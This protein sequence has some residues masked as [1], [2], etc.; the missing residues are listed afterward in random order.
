MQ[1]ATKFKD[2]SPNISL[3]PNYK[4][5]QIFG[6]LDFDLAFQPSMFKDVL[7]KYARVGSVGPKMKCS[8]AFLALQQV[9]P[10]DTYLLKIL[11]F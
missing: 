10:D 2:L 6:P 3:H 8:T 5:D 11:L 9:L 1:V 4:L 7:L